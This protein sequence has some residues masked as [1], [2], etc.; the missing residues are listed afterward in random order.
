MTRDSALNE[1]VFE[2]RTCH[3]GTQECPTDKNL[4]V[5]HKVTFEKEDKTSNHTIKNLSFMTFSVA[6][7]HVFR[8]QTSLIVFALTLYF[9]EIGTLRPFSNFDG[10]K[11]EAIFPEFSSASLCR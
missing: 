1:F 11:D 6:N 3:P 10:S 4:Q 8:F 5:R 7:A 2:A 9:F